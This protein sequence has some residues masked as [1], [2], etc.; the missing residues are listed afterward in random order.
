MLIQRRPG[1][2]TIST[3]GSVRSGGTSAAA[4]ER[5]PNGLRGRLGTART[6]RLV[7][8]GGHAGHSTPPADPPLR[9]ADSLLFPT[10]SWTHPEGWRDWPYETPPTLPVARREKVAI[11]TG[12]KTN[13]LGDAVQ[14]LPGR[15]RV[16]DP[17]AAH[18]GGGQDHMPA[19][20]LKCKEC[21]TAYELE[22]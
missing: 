6:E 18:P 9:P 17:S 20:A 3:R 7:G 19:D 13:G 16:S 14:G 5:R 12:S 22:A 4:R 15:T 10:H 1:D 2:S 11:P 8:R 21:G